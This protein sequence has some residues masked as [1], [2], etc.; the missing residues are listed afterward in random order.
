MKGDNRR[1]WETTGDKTTSEPKKPT[2]PTN[3]KAARFKVALRTPTV[4]CLGKKHSSSSTS[5]SSRCSRDSRIR[6]LQRGTIRCCTNTSSH[7]KYGWRQDLLWMDLHGHC[8]FFLCNLHSFLTASRARS[9]S[10]ISHKSRAN[11]PKANESSPRPKQSPSEGAQI[12]S[13][14]LYPST[15][16]RWLGLTDFS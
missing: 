7:N 4:N 13:L 16:V 9:I 15:L 14:A 12:R 6:W 1:Q 5:Q 10:C 3:T 2:T 11:G 8:T